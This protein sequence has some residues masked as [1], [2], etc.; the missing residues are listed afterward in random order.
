MPETMTDYTT[1]FGVNCDQQLSYSFVHQNK[2]Q[3]VVQAKAI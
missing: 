3:K 2:V 1:K